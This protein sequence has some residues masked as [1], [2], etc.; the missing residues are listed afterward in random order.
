MEKTKQTLI[1]IVKSLVDHHESIVVTDS[2]DDM[3]VLL[4][5]HVHREDMGKVIGKEGHTAN[6]IRTLIRTIGMKERSRISLK[7]AE[8]EG[9]THTANKYQPLEDL[10]I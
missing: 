2:N 4:T 6:A 10:K 9:S 7:I 1:T 3:G 5:L 8:H